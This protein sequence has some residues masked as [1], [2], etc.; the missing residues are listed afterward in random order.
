MVLFWDLEI[1][2]LPQVII[3]ISRVKFRIIIENHLLFDNYK[4]FS[5]IFSKQFIIIIYQ[6]ELL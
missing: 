4:H 3:H 6:I 5:V 1:Y 2:T